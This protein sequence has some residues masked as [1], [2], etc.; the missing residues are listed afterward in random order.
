[1]FNSEFDA[2]ARN[3][4]VDL[5]P[6]ALR[7]EIDDLNDLVY[8]TVNHGVYRAGFAASQEKYEEAANDVFATLDSLESRLEIGRYLC[9]DRITEAD[10]RLFPTLI[11]FDSVYYLHFKCNARRLVDYPSLS[12]F[13]R[14]LYQVRGV[15][16]TVNFAHIKHHYYRSHVR[17]NPSGLVPIG[18]DENFEA[19][20]RREEMSL[21]RA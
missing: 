2:F 21:L 17:L 11:R 13:T 3:P 8:R 9:G 1:M 19:P 4:A 7:V 14:E 20:H 18:P 12:A 16:E 10:W 5:Y 6:T 15:A